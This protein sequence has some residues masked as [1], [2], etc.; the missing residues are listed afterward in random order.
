MKTLPVK[1]CKV[2]PSKPRGA[3][4]VNGWDNG[5]DYDAGKP[6]NRS[7]TVRA[8]DEGD[9]ETVADAYWLRQ[10]IRCEVVSA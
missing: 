8:M 9:A 3:Y 7:H 6:A 5:A 10:G 4:T 2:K 1:V